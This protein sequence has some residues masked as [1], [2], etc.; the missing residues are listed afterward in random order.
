MCENGCEEFSSM[1]IKSIRRMCS[2]F[3]ELEN[4]LYAVERQ[5]KRLDQVLGEHVG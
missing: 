1:E 2:L 3:D 4:R 5:S